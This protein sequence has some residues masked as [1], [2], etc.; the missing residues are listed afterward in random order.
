MIEIIYKTLLLVCCTQYF[1]LSCSMALVQK[2]VFNTLFHLKIKMQ[3]KIRT[4]YVT[5]ISITLSF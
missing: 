4:F 3:K 1:H 5:F 2:E